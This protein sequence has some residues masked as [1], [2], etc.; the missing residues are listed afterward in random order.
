MGIS[1]GGL[2]LSGRAAILEQQFFLPNSISWGCKN[3]EC[4][5]LSLGWACTIACMLLSATARGTLG[6]QCWVR[7]NTSN[8]V[9][10]SQSVSP[11]LMYV[12]FRFP[13]RS[14]REKAQRAAAAI[15]LAVIVAH[16]PTSVAS[17]ED[18]SAHSCMPRTPN[19]ARRQTSAHFARRLQCQNRPDDEL[20]L[21]VCWCEVE[22]ESG[23]ML[24]DFAD[25]HSFK[26]LNTFRC[27]SPRATTW[28]DNSGGHHRLDYVI[29]DAVTSESLSKL[30]VVDEIDLS[31]A[32]REDRTPVAACLPLPVA[33]ARRPRKDSRPAQWSERDL[34]DPDSRLMLF[35]VLLKTPTG[36]LGVILLT[37]FSRAF[38]TL[39]KSMLKSFSRWAPCS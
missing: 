15:T 16:A 25:E 20:L 38:R 18:K 33:A 29:S 32:V 19:E 21:W 26:L 1:N 11:R 24:R 34:A 10:Y 37:S 28:A 13:N 12:V 35:S 3:R 4:K 9:L 23:S 8:F 2:A 5:V 7:S 36:V 30:W 14:D 6:V 31:T 27:D 22:I 39:R 17:L